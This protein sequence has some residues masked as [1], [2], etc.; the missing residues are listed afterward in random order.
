MYPNVSTIKGLI[1]DLTGIEVLEDPQE[2]MPV[3]DPNTAGQLFIEIKAG[4]E[5]G[6][7][8][9]E[10]S[11]DGNTELQVTTQ[12]GNRLFTCSVKMISC[13]STRNAYK[14]LELL[15]SKLKRKSSLDVLRAQNITIY[16]AEAVSTLPTTFDNR[17]VSVANLDLHMSYFFSEVDNTVDGVWI[18]TIELV[19]ET[20]A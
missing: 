9:F 2:S 4:A 1:Q 6:V 10:L 8:D 7:D 18:E 19:D 15:R 16:R 14:T 5:L 13:D 20:E 11:Y 3:I 17:T 12:K